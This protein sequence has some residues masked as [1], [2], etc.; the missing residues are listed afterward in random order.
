MRGATSPQPSS[1]N[2]SS[3]KTTG[4]GKISGT[5]KMLL[6]LREVCLTHKESQKN[7]QHGTFL[8]AFQGCNEL[9]VC[10]MY[11]FFLLHDTVYVTIC[12]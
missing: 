9:N 10:M 2:T 6:S 5:E 1:Q 7:I 11:M 4:Y 12:L 8:L 3:G